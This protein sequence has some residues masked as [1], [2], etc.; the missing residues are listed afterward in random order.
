MRLANESA[1]ASPGSLSI[2]VPEPAEADTHYINDHADPAVENGPAD[3]VPG[4]PYRVPPP[5]TRPVY[6][7]RLHWTLD[8]LAQHDADPIRSSP[9]GFRT[10]VGPHEPTE[11]GCDFA[12]KLAAAS[13]EVFPRPFLAAAEMSIGRSI[14]PA[15]PPRA[16]QRPVEVRDGPHEMKNHRRCCRDFV[17]C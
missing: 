1:L 15:S 7:S 14:R 8:D 12:I 11:T 4:L 13:R 16:S 5:A 17:P 2:P 9:L 6:S 3:Y 10:R